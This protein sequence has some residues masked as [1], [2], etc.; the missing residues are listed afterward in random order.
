MVFIAYLKT[1]SELALADTLL[2]MVKNIVSREINRC[3]TF[4]VTQRECGHSHPQVPWL[5]VFVR[6]ALAGEA[7]FHP[8]ASRRSA[9]S[10][11]RAEEV[12]Y[13]L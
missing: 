11:V 6:G 10:S 5:G 1:S 13:L 8:K 7:V 12:L 4:P 9:G 3:V 2:L